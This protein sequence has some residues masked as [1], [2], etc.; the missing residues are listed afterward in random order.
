MFLS[1]WACLQF[2]PS[3]IT[4]MPAQNSAY[5]HLFTVKV[6]SF[7]SILSAGYSNQ[8]L[9]RTVFIAFSVGKTPSKSHFSTFVFRCCETRTTASSNRG[10]IFS[11]RRYLQETFPAHN[12]EFQPWLIIYSAS[13]ALVV[14][15]MLQMFNAIVGA[16]TAAAFA[17]SVSLYCTT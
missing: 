15:F 14:A 9:E 5:R 16:W 17:I 13:T 1:M 4:I 6:M 2:F 11:L 10:S 3:V 7:F 8:F 12:G